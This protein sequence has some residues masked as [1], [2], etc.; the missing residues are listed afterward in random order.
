MFYFWT[1]LT[2]HTA[3]WCLSVSKIKTD[4]EERKV[5]KYENHK[6][7]ERKVKT[8]TRNWRDHRRT[9]THKHTETVSRISYVGYVLNNGAMYEK[10]WHYF[11]F[12]KEQRPPGL[13]S[14]S[15]GWIAISSTYAYITYASQ[16]NLEF[17]PGKYEMNPRIRILPLT[18]VNGLLGGRMSK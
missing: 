15:N 12:V 5:P 7:K 18:S 6:L 2:D 4:H 11:T 1:I 16:N 9:G 3:G 13:M 14:P 10:V 8:L 17:N